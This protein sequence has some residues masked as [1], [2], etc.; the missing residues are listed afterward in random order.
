[1]RRRRWQLRE[2]D[3]VLRLYEGDEL[4]AE[5]I[6]EVLEVV[7]KCPKCGAPALAAYTTNMGYIYAWH[8]AEDGKKHA[9]Y[10]GKAEGP[11]LTILE[12]LRRREIE[13]SKE[14]REILYKVYIKKTRATKEERKRA[15]EILDMLLKARKVVIYGGV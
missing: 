2:E 8:M 5:G 6:E 11:W 14:D 7:S 1:M 10:L 3:G 15:R 4:I 12:Y 13:L 9:W